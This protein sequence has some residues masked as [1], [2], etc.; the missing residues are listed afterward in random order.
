VEL[1]HGDRLVL[2][3]GNHVYVVII[4]QV[5]AQLAKNPDPAASALMTYRAAMREFVTRRTETDNER[6][7]RLMRGAAAN[8]LQRKYQE[9]FEEE[10][11]TMIRMMDDANELAIELQQPI[12]FRILLEHPLQAQKIDTLTLKNLISYEAVRINVV[13]EVPLLSLSFLP[14][15]PLIMIIAPRSTAA[16]WASPHMRFGTTLNLDLVLDLDP[17]RFL[18]VLMAKGRDIQRNGTGWCG[19]FTTTCTASP[20]RRCRRPRCTA[21]GLSL[22]FAGSRARSLGRCVVS[23]RLSTLRSVAAASTSSHR[24][25]PQA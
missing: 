15:P 14:P 11:V 7:A 19:L 5:A 16:C 21:P 3:N 4:P 1:K 2:G 22:K 9:A 10:L 12:R 23:S 8:F 25:P 20:T 18:I 24:S 6:Q 17:P 13:V